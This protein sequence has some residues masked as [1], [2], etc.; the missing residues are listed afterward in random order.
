M[1]FSDILFL[2]CLSEIGG[3]HLGTNPVAPTEAYGVGILYTPPPPL[4]P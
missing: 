3:I 2:S 1:T 4:S